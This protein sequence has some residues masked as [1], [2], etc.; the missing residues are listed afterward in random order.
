[1]TAALKARPLT[2]KQALSLWANLRASFLQFQDVLEK[3]IE[4][5][6]WEPLGYESFAE[7]WTAKMSDITLAAEFRAH[8]VYQMFA[9]GLDVDAVAEA[10]KG[11]GRDRAE[12][13]KRQRSNGVPA[14]HASLSTPRKKWFNKP[15]DG[16]TVVSEHLRKPPSAQRALHLDF[17]PTA[18]KRFQRI[19]KKHGLSV[20]DIARDAV[21]SK[22][23]ELGDVG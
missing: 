22:F 17:S 13:L 8:V 4:E 19:A 2:A 9:D 12:S 14:A 23:K 1:M 7:A 5:K 6:A 16:S 21:M 10:V 20:D 11:V 3:I 18:I 15:S